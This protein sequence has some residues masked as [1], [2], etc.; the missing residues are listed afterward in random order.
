VGAAWPVLLVAASMLAC[1]RI[2]GGDYS[3][4]QRVSRHLLKNGPVP[5]TGF[6]PIIVRE[7]VYN[8]YN[9]LFREIIQ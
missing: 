7:L 6:R 1:R 2:H 4:K 3:A 8:L 5:K 9:P